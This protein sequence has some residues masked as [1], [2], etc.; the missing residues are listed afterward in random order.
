[1]TITMQSKLTSI[2]KKREKKKRKPLRGDALL[3]AQTVGTL[4]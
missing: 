2:K 3:M 4:L 1:M